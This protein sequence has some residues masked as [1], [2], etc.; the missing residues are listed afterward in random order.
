VEEK[1]PDE[2]TPKG[3]FNKKVRKLASLGLV[4]LLVGFIFKLIGSLC[5]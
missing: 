4:I 2:N 3:R 1:E 5:A